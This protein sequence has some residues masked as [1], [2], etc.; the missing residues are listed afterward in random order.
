MLGFV[1]RNIHTHA[2]GYVIGNREGVKL[3]FYIGTKP[4]AINRLFCRL[5]LGWKWFDNSNILPKYLIKYK[6]KGGTIS[7]ITLDSEDIEV[8]LMEISKQPLWNGFTSITQL[9]K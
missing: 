9:N 7:E 8:D 4:N 5:L 1:A 2:G 3:E 6:T